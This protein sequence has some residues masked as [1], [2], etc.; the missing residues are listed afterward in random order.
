MK[1]GHDIDGSN[2]YRYSLPMNKPTPQ[3][4]ERRDAYTAGLTRYYTGIPC[5]Q[6]HLAQRYVSTGGCVECQNRFTQRRH[7]TRKDLQPYVCAKLWVPT[8]TTPA[9]YEQLAT[10]LQTCIDAYFEHVK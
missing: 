6:G 7:P 4:I 5:R 3:L 2:V 9:Q 10:Y 1:S 8:G